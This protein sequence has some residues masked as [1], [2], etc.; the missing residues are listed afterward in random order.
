[1]KSPAPIP[2]AVVG[3]LYV[4]KTPDGQENWI[5]VNDGLWESV[6]AAH[7]HPFLKGYVLSFLSNGEP[8]WVTKES[9]RTYKG[10][11]KK[12]LQGM[13]EG[14]ADSEAQ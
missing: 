13:R 10:R 4:H 3:S 12:M 5:R 14:T 2:D 7:P 8:R 6:Q 11:E 1:M 9:L